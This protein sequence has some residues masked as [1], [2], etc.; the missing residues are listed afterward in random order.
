LRAA[1]K[2]RRCA[3]SAPRR[4]ALKS[5]EGAF[6]ASTVLYCVLAMGFGV[7]AYFLTALWV[8]AL[9]MVLLL[10]GVWG[11]FRPAYFEADGESL[12][13]VWPW[14]RRM[15]V[16]GQILRAWRL[17]LQALRPV[18]RVGVGGL[19]GTFGWLLRPGKGRL[20]AYI[21]ARHDLVLLQLESG[22]PLLLS[23]EDPVAFLNCLGLEEEM[24]SF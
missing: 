2:K 7:F 20:E 23:P 8:P 15:L 3:V 22:W 19:L 12:H 1:Q 5:L 18:V 21:T 24:G 4:F 11:W 9:G 13:I 10:F 14:R 16:R 17:D 6:L